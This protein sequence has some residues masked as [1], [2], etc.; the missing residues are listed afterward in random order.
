MANDRRCYGLFYH[1]DYP[2]VFDLFTS[3]EQFY[4]ISDI[5]FSMD[6]RTLNAF[7]RE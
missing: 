4:Y 3:L 1:R 2:T 5:M 7:I 6:P